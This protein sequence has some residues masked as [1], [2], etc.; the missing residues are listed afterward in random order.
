MRIGVKLAV[1]TA[2][3]SGMLLGRKR[4][5]EDEHFHLKG[6]AASVSLL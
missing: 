3:N 6:S 4:V 5:R 1:L 2:M